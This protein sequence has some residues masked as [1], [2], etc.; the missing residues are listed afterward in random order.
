[1]AVILLNGNLNCGFLIQLCSFRAAVEVV[2]PDGERIVR[3]VQELRADSRSWI[4][5]KEKLEKWGERNPTKWVGEADFCKTQINLPQS[6]KASTTIART[7]PSTIPPLPMRIKIA[8]RFP[9]ENLT[10]R[11][12]RR[13]ILHWE[14]IKKWRLRRMSHQRL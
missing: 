5:E 4:M 10:L 6:C 13:R 12:F 9:W 1:M 3:M 8:C 2:C 7:E 11:I 14:S